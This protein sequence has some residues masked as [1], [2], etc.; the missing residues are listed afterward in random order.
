[1]MTFRQGGTGLQVSIAASNTTTAIPADATGTVVAITNPSTTLTIY[2]RLVGSS[3]T[4]SAATD[5]AI[6]PSQTAYLDRSP[7][8]DTH[9]ALFGS[10]AG[11]TLV[12]VAIGEARFR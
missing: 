10:G 3:A 8:L 9:V 4:A 1:M 2:A 7:T 11:P 5:F 12:N 6:P